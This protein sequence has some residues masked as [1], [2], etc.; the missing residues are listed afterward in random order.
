MAQDIP[1]KRDSINSVIL[2]EKRYFQVILPAGYSAASG[3]KYDVIYVLDG[4]GNTKLLSD[5]EQLLAGEGRIPH[6]IIIGITG[7]KI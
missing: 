3:E 4:D 5:V 2:K 6:N 7:K 1:G